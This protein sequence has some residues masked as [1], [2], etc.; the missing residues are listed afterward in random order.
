MSFTHTIDHLKDAALGAAVGSTQAIAAGFAPF[1]ALRT[2]AKSVVNRSIDVYTAAQYSAFASMA[3]GAI[4]SAG[5]SDDPL[6]A[7]VAVGVPV[8]NALFE[9]QNLRTNGALEQ[10]V[11]DAVNDAIPIVYDVAASTHDVREVKTALQSYG[12]AVVDYFRGTLRNPF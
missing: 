1:T 4:Y 8:A 3:A 6:Y 7:A 12:R 11:C 9:I 2:M 5:T 10:R